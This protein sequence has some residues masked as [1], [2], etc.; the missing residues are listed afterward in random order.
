LQENGALK[1]PRYQ[2]QRDGTLLEVRGADRLAEPAT[3]AMAITLNRPVVQALADGRVVFASQPIT[4]PIVGSGLEL[5]PCL[6]VIS[7][8]GAQ[9]RPVPTV[10]G[11]LPTN[12]AYFTVSPDGKSAAVVEG[13]T[14]A[15]AVVDL[16]SGKTAIVSPPHPH[17]QCRTVP[18]WKSAT[19]LTF[20][21][22]SGDGNTPTWVLWS[23]DGGIRSLSGKW[24][25]TAA[26]KWL[27]HKK[28]AA[29]KEPANA[30][31]D[32]TR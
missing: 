13:E 1:K 8:D 3:L 30:K 15:V 31:P 12:L 25:A 17:W 21:A 27:E 29:F 5:E 20:A 4:L 26:A 2:R 22:L 32:S 28:S 11:D 7:A 10:R 16:D 14:D 19:E 18:A 23:R 6:F 9:V 24:P